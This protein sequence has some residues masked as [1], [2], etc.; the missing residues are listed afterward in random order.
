[1]STPRTS[2]APRGITEPTRTPIEPFSFMRWVEEH[3][4]QLRPPVCNKQVY[5]DS[6]FI[7]MVVGGPNNRTDYHY[8]EGEELF[9]VIKGELTV[10]VEPQDLHRTAALQRVVLAPLAGEEVLHRRE[11]ERAEP[12]PARVGRA[13]VAFL[14]KLGEERLGQ[15]ASLVGTVAA[16]AGIGVEGVPVLGAQC[17]QSLLGAFSTGVARR[18][19]QAPA[20]GRKPL[21]AARARWAVG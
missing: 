15:V 9:F 12:A 19:H 10:E 5:R 18:E 17:R 3:R 7:V 14:E 2:G 20:R 21:A 4:D 8:N 13:Q 11:Q 16:A 6:D 1:M